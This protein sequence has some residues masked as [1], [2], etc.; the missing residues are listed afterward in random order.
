MSPQSWVFHCIRTSNISKCHNK[1]ISEY[2]L[3]RHRTLISKLQNLVNF[4]IY[5]AKETLILV[6]LT[7]FH[8]C[9]DNSPY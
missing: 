1:Y 9:T 6:P 5:N 2:L 7:L 3:T 4:V 8:L